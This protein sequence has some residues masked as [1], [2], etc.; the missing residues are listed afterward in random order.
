MADPSDLMDRLRQGDA[1]AF[2][3]FA[4]AYWRKIYALALSLSGNRADAEDLTQ[5]VL[6]KV[7][8]GF[9][10]YVQKAGNLEAFVHRMTV[11]LWIDW[12][13]RRRRAPEFSLDGALDRQ[14]GSA[15]LDLPDP[16][17]GV[18]EVH[19][20]EFWSAVWQ[21]FGELPESYR[22]L[23]KLRAVDR[24]SYKEIAAALGESEAAVRAKLNRS[25]ALLREKLR[26]RGFDPRQ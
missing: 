10:Q 17:A 7:Y 14:E 18:E 22:V 25:R 4:A 9:S 5:E 3:E 13:R 19:R 6:L 16:E 12:V 24:M 21:A 23:L 1:S 15:G 8:Q 2:E 20:K 11:N 26:R